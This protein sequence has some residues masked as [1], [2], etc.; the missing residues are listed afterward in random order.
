MAEHQLPKLTVRVRF[1]SPAPR[2][3]PWS[4]HCPSQGLLFGGDPDRA[5]GH[6]RAIHDSSAFRG[7]ARFRRPRAVVP[8]P[9][10]QVPQARASLGREGVARMPEVVAVEP[11]HPDSRHGVRLLHELVEVP[12]PDRPAVW[13][14]EHV[15]GQ[16][17]TD[18]VTEVVPDRRKHRGPT[19]ADKVCR[20]AAMT[21][22]C[23]M[24]AIFCKSAGL[25]LPHNRRQP[26]TQPGSKIFSCTPRALRPGETG[27]E[28]V[29]R[30]VKDRDRLRSP[31]TSDDLHE[32]QVIRGGQGGIEP[33][34]FRFSVGLATA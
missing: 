13:S 4:G 24:R 19:L 9:S 11:G 7:L 25:A 28:V 29:N 10:H 18:M 6:P 26:S 5:S 20:S 34:T 15:G 22:L 14:R 31:E 33:P 1:P 8:H 2:K 17:H 16:L 30:G 12:A 23:R 32:W 21:D 3:K 27:F